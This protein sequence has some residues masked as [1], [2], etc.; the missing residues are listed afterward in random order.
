MLL[1]TAVKSPPGNGRRIILVILA[2]VSVATGVFIFALAGLPDR[3]VY[4]GFQIEGETFA[5]EIGSLAPPFTAAARTREPVDM[6]ALRGKPVILNFWATWCAPCEAELPE[7][8][9]FQAA[10]GDSVNL[11]ALNTGE[12]PEWANGWLDAR[13]LTLDVAYDPDAQIASLYRLRGQPTTF[14]VSPNGIITAIFYGPV[15]QHQL[16]TVLEAYL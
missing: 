8:Q 12:T 7:L 2:L 15:T 5:P 11:I 4:S 1:Q 13:Q 10:H 3:A 9:L 14:I 16:E 6:L